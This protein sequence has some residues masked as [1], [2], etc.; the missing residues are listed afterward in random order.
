MSL[1][2]LCPQCKKAQLV[3]YQYVYYNPRTKKNEIHWG[4]KCPKCGFE[5][6][7]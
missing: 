1:Y 4:A 7:G 2:G 5:T 6:K 3:R